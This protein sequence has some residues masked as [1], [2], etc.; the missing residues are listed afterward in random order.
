MRRNIIIATTKSWNLR[1]SG[2][3]A[4]NLH[5]KY[6][7]EIYSSPEDF[8]YQNVKALAPKFIFFPHWSWKIGADIF[9]NFACILFHMTDLPFGRG[10]S[11]LQNL[12]LRKRY[13]TKISAIKVV[14]ELDAGD[15]YLQE[16]FNLSDGSAETLFKAI[17]DI[18]FFKMIPRI[19]AEEPQPR[20][21]E[22]EV[23]VF[24]RRK[25]EQ[26]NLENC[27][28]ED[29]EDLYDFVRMLDAEGYPNA[30]LTIDKLKIRLNNIRKVNDKLVGQFEV[31]DE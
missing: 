17:S 13:K 9:E 26:S 8:T 30:F 15:I 6:N 20:K 31:S 27:R 23:V 12:I 28:L 7:L 21:Q 14:K 24:K 25:P 16:D 5:G 18:I 22:G 1:N 11:P 4:E 10:G 29:L 3:L 2:V 19:L